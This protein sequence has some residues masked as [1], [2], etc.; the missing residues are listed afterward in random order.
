MVELIYPSSPAPLLSGGKRARAVE[1]LPVVDEYGNVKAQASREY[2]HTNPSHPL[3]PVAHLHIINRKGEIYLQRR[4]AH[5][6]LLPLYWDTA[7][8]GHVSYGESILEALYRETREELGLQDFMPHW[9]CTYVFE[10]A[11]ERELVNVFAAVG[12]YQIRP[13]PGELAGGR[14]W[15]QEEIVEATGKGILTPNFESEFLR[16][17]DALL[18]L[19]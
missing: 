4:G 14:F 3:H 7:V 15:T 17:K 2:C 11:A 5:K 16:V 6:D 1:M 13:D 10:G 9:L 19:L 8:G 12:E 18:A